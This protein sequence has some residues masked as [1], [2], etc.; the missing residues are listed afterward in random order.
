MVSKGSEELRRVETQLEVGFSKNCGEKEE[1]VKGETFARKMRERS[2]GK[3][4]EQRN[5]PRS[6]QGDVMRLSKVGGV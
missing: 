3:C 1:Q 5:S 4:H 2:G 6:D